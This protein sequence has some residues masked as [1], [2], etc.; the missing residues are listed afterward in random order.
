MDDLMELANSAADQVVE[1]PQRLSNQQNGLSN[2]PAAGGSTQASVQ[3][4]PD[5]DG[6]IRRFGDS[7]KVK[8]GVTGSVDSNSHE[9]AFTDSA[10]VG[11][12]Q[13]SQFP[14]THLTYDLASCQRPSLHLDD[15]Q[16]S[17]A[18]VN[19]CHP[20]ANIWSASTITGHHGS[21]GHHDDLDFD[22]D[23]DVCEGPLSDGDYGTQHNLPAQDHLEPNSASSAE[24]TNGTLNLD[25]YLKVFH[26]QDIKRDRLLTVSTPIPPLNSSMNPDLIAESLPRG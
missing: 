12:P 5:K 3:R 18:W 25:Q 1:L 23:Y 4:S 7:A 13:T 21:P 19:G 10:D 20:A 15:E 9:K 24:T 26:Q 8:E 22:E 6:Y 2:S 16:T 14:I 17:E 11:L